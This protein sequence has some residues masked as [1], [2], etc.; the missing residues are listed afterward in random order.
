MPKS[1]DLPASPPQPKKS[2]F[3]RANN[4]LPDSS[5]EKLRDNTKALVRVL[6]TKDMEPLRMCLIILIAISN[7]QFKHDFRKSGG[8]RPIAKLLSLPDLL[9]DEDFVVHLLVVVIALVTVEENREQFRTV[10][11]LTRIIPFLS[12]KD[13]K[14][15]LMATEAL[16]NLSFNENNQP[17]IIAAHAL[18]QIFKNA[19]TPENKMQFESV[20]L[21]RNLAR[22]DIGKERLNE[23]HFRQLLPLLDPAKVYR[24]ANSAAFKH[25]LQLNRV[26]LECLFE[27]AQLEK[28]RKILGQLGLLRT[29][30]GFFLPMRTGSGAQWNFDVLLRVLKI[31]ETML[32]YPSNRDQFIELKGV[33]LVAAILQKADDYPEPVLLEAASILTQIATKATMNKATY[34]KLGLQLLIAL[35]KKFPNN[36]VVHDL[37]AQVI[38]N[39]SANQN[40][41]Q[42]V[43]QLGG[44]R[45]LMLFLR[46][47]RVKQVLVEACA[48]LANLCSEERVVKSIIQ[49]RVVAHLIG[50]LQL[51][52]AELQTNVSRVLANVS[53]GSDEGVSE[54]VKN[55][56]IVPLVRL[57]SDENAL[58][59]EQVLLTFGKLLFANGK[60]GPQNIKYFMQA[61]GERPL[62]SQQCMLA[63]VEEVQVPALS[64]IQGASCLPQV[65]DMLIDRIDCGG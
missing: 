19:K 10:N 45:V 34:G 55:G 40:N 29:L 30:Q 62:L 32:P 7:D 60:L 35:L 59:R 23:D 46:E 41:R 20:F 65:N 47:S 17:V 18:D 24:P 43:V 57:M 27:C 52:Q 12:H 2:L 61:G 11:G 64:I 25:I 56:G 36:E 53:D 9:D 15:V 26:V 3:V 63:E 16:L 22:C 33:P 49:G 31:I 54:I 58:V 8:L 5:A 42:M 13:G 48:G 38:S 1:L 44:D 37:V 21:I 28:N 39:V 6:N 51:N 4:N 14:I 50:L